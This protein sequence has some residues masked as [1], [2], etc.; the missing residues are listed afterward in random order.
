MAGAERQTENG[1]KKEPARSAQVLVRFRYGAPGEI[2]TPGLQVRSLL[3]YPAELRAR[4]RR[5]KYPKPQA[6]SSFF[7]KNFSKI[8]HC[9]PE[10]SKRTATNG[11]RLPCSQKGSQDT[12]QARCISPVRPIGAR[13]LPQRSCGSTPP[14]P[15]LPLP[16]EQCRFHC[17]GAAHADGRPGGISTHHAAHHPRRDDLA[18]RLQRATRRLPG[19]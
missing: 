5:G 16:P 6:A 17:P 3:L 19:R 12:S 9:Y 10:L 7:P 8:L 15:V 11:A 2:R 18:V 1:I 13:P 4:Q 14:T